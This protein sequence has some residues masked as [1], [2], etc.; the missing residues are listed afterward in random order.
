MADNNNKKDPI[1]SFFERKVRDHDISYNEADWKKLQDKLDMLD[2]EHAIWQRRLW[3]VAASILLFS[4]LGYFT[5]QN[6][7]NIN[8]LS[9]Q[10]NRTNPINTQ[11][12]TAKK[13]LSSGTANPAINDQNSGSIADADS[14]KRTSNTPFNLAEG[15]PV[16]PSQPNSDNN[17]GNTAE[18][19]QAPEGFLVS[20][21][22]AKEL[23]IPELSIMPE[24]ALNSE[25]Y[26]LLR[27]K[28]VSLESEHTVPVY[29]ANTEPTA[30]VNSENKSR[31]QAFSR[32]SLGVLVG[33][34]LSTVGSFSNFYDPGYTI[35][36]KAEYSFTPRLSITA[37]I[38]QSKVRYLAQGR[39]YKPPRGFW[40]NGIIPRETV[41]VCM[42]IDIPI[43]LKYNVLEFTGARF[44]A[45]AG[46]TSYIMLDE[47]YRFNYD[48]GETGLVQGWSGE[49]GTRHWLSNA[50]FSIGY[51]W[52]LY[53]KWS[54]R[55]EPFVKI[56]LKEVGWGNVNLYSLGSFI[57]INYTIRKAR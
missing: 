50:G 28:I 19:N 24:M 40:T 54:I 46:L 45:T 49:T 29:A 30:L 21:D 36:F 27:L 5:Y 31:P 16:V 1:E 26:A 3:I 17:K 56:P 20:G 41:G 4:L 33:P 11:Q 7:T 22:T 43:S 13:D 37:G 15:Q 35:G 6:Y 42:L 39:E 57:S 55:A 53:P 38:Q 52:D 8:R 47:D 23:F 25:S 12:D 9:Q 2:K 32:F 14:L 10:I 34:D 48:S 18:D 44:Y 51:E